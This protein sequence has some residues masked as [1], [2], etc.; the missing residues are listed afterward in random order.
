MQ[1]GN[2]SFISGQKEWTK[3]GVDGLSMGNLG[4]QIKKTSAQM[5]NEADKIALQSLGN[6]AIDG[7]SKKQS[8][9]TDQQTETSEFEGGSGG[10]AQS[11]N[12]SKS[13][14]DEKENYN[15]YKLDDSKAYTVKLNPISQLIELIDTESHS[16]IE[17]I[18]PND[19]IK[20]VYKL[21]SASGILVNKKI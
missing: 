14:T 15:E 7:I 4:I 8:T 11:D 12:D 13:E 21:N 9:I 16:V 1:F 18:S 10:N 6:N 20:L 2:K 5:A 3:M 17:T 19:L